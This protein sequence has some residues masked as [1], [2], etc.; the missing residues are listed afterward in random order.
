MS[1]VRVVRGSR[2]KTVEG[3]GRSGGQACSMLHVYKACLVLSNG[4]R[5]CV[6]S[7]RI[8]SFTFVASEVALRSS[9]RES[10]AARLGL[11]ADPLA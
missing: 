6:I 3:A 10:R 8:P 1:D 4:K 7:I 2:R 11:G 9:R 5:L